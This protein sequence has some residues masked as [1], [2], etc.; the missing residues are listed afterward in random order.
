MNL[1]LKILPHTNTKIFSFFVDGQYKKENILNN[2]KKK[3]SNMNI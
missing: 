2:K 3:N 1:I